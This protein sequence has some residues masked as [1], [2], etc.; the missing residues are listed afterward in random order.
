MND[1][2]DTFTRIWAKGRNNKVVMRIMAKVAI[3][4]LEPTEENCRDYWMGYIRY[5][6]DAYTGKSFHLN[7]RKN[8]RIMKR[9]KRSRE[10]AKRRPK[11]GRKPHPMG[12]HRNQKNR[13]HSSR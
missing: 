10:Y 6:V 9:L 5:Y 4:G 11:S 12:R 3:R 7:P 2:W 8:K 13:R 1:R